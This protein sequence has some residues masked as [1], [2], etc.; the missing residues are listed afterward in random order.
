MDIYSSLTSISVNSVSLRTFPLDFFPKLRTLS[1]IECPNLGS[2]R[3]NGIYCSCELESE[4]LKV[5]DCSFERISKDKRRW[6][7]GMDTL[8]VTRGWEEICTDCER[9]VVHWLCG[10]N[11]VKDCVHLCNRL[12]G[13]GNRLQT[14]LK[15]VILVTGRGIGLKR[16]EVPVQA[17]PDSPPTWGVDSSS[18][19]SKRRP[20]VLATHME[21]L[22]SALDGK[23]SLG[24]DSAA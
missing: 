18:S 20:K 8:L 2:V 10:Y 12:R 15:S 9:N 7:C 1:I 21:F 22:A 11:G 3:M 4:D 17:Q 24:C 13:S 6:I 19:A 14:I 5:I 16:E 23:I